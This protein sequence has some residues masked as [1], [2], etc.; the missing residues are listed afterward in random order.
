VPGPRREEQAFLSGVSAR[1]D[2]PDRTR[3]Q[4]T[5]RMIRD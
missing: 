3:P 1:H 5:I 4:W 2:T